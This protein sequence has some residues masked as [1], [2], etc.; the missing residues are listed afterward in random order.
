MGN[1]KACLLYTKFSSVCHFKEAS[2]QEM[3]GGRLRVP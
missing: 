2:L 1:L 3:G